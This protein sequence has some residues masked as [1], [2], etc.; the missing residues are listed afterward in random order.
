MFVV[1]S[2]NFR[3]NNAQDFLN[4]V[5]SEFSNLYVYLAKTSQWADEEN[6]DEVT[7]S[8]KE[9]RAIWDEMS[10]LK[11]VRVTDIIRGAR[12]IV[13]ESGTVYTQYDDAIDMTEENFYIFTQENNIYICIS[14]NNGGVST[15]R[16][17]HISEQVVEEIDGYKWKYITTLSSS[18]L[19]KFVIPGYIPIQT[20]TDIIESAK[21]GGIHRLSLESPGLGYQEDR[22]LNNNNALGVFIQGNG[23]QNATSLVNLVTVSGAISSVD[24]ISGGYDYAFSPSVPFPVA[25]R[26]ITADGVIQTAYG[27][28]TASFTGEID[29]IE[30]SIRGSGYIDGQA[31]I[32]QSSAE[33]YAETDELGRVVST[34]IILGKEGLGFKKAS[35]IVVPPAYIEMTEEAS[36]IPVISPPGGFGSNQFKDVF[37]NYLIISVE[38]NP[39]DLDDIIELDQFR[40]IGIID[41][42]ETYESELDSLGLPDYVSVDVADSKH[43]LVLTGS[44]MSFIDSEDIVGMTSGAIGRNMSKH[45]SNIL[46]YNPMDDYFSEDSIPF[47]VGEQVH[48]L[49]SGASSVVSEVISPDTRKYSGDIYHINNIKHIVRSYDQTTLLTFAIKY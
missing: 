49:S 48:G 24:I 2:S 27:M 11:K 45:D 7:F 42:P 14:N 18:I 23:E 10:I 37:A 29:S 25:I 36:I 33:G 34:D 39:N 6:P 22:T 16:P 38:I 12:E 4:Y 46:R 17:T 30:V 5:Q 1:P 9:K 15:I 31:F 28:A 41:S 20:K 35:A 47:V 32:V 26:Q 3:Y 19:N 21:D 8:E 43:R 44:N 40:R 13:W